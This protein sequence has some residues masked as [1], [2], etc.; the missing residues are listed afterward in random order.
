MMVDMCKRTKNC[1]VL[2]I[3]FSVQLV[4]VVTVW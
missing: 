4:V 1:A 3:F 2:S